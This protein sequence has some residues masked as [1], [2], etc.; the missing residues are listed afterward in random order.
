VKSRARRLR[1]RLASC[2]A[3]IALVTS[4]TSPTDAAAVDVVA[5]AA[6][7]PLADRV[8]ADLLSMGVDAERAEAPAG[9]VDLLAIA[10]HEG[11]A[12]AVRI[13]RVAGGVEVWVAE[14]ATGKT[15]MRTAA[16]TSEDDV[17][18]LALRTVELLRASLIELDLPD[19]AE[20]SHGDASAEEVEALRAAVPPPRRAH[21]AQA[22]QAVPTP[23]ARPALRSGDDDGD[24]VEP[25]GGAGA[26]SAL[27][28]SL[29]AGPAI[30]ASPGG[31]PPFAALHAI[32]GVRVAA[33]VRV[34]LFTI[35]PLQA[36]AHGSVEATSETRVHLA[37]IDAR[38]EPFEGDLRPS[39]ALQVNA[40][41]VSTEGRPR[42]TSYSHR[43]DH[44]VAGG[45]SMR[46]GLAWSL[47][48][49]V[50]V[51]ADATG[52]ALLRPFAVTYA[53]REIAEWG[54]AWFSGCVA[55]EATID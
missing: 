50:A 19:L 41:F 8:T 1:A 20:T 12:A 38:Y 3:S 48:P 27:A 22:T 36:M 46:A 26:T 24:K 44:G 39:V 43:A 9:A 6:D 17:A 7:A 14:R 55:V 45:P 4:I 2:L 25:G 42:T 51:R 18:T 13:V 5:S 37:G 54:R 10:R 15:L 28:L 34:G 29:E 30:V 16:T 35:A 52:G 33:P 23:T 11:A 53:E 47:N 21:A 40:A 32:V 31:L 49:H